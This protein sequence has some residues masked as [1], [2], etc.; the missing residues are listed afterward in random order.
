MTD[1]PVKESEVLRYLGQRGTEADDAVLSAVR[2]CIR[3]LKEE[4]EPKRVYRFFPLIWE[5]ENR[6]RIE[7][8]EV[9]SRS[10]GKNFRGCGEVC[11]M[12]ATIGFA[13]DRHV[14]RE[15]ALGRVSRA[16]IFQAAGAALIESWCDLVN[17]E[18][19][20]K[21]E[22]RGLFLRPRFSPG[23]GD[24][25]I[26]HQPEFMRILSVQKEI[27]VTLTETC[28]MMPSKSVTAVIGMSK[29]NAH[30]LTAGCEAC[31]KTDCLYR[32][33]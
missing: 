3:I 4:S 10:L 5:G 32:R 20:R 1:I 18:I 16:V 25:S 31:G 17:E 24:F 9:A 22:K 8:M 29:E 11:L 15:T 19:R 6:F 2:S 13:T 26:S 14:E 21:A 30:C 27:G 7:G 12:A 28:L 23:Y 33:A